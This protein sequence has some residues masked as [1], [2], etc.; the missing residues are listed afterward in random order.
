[1]RRKIVKIDE[2]KCNGCGDCVPSCAEGAIKITDGKARLI[3]ESLCDGFGACL[4][5]Y[6]LGA[7]T[8]EKRAAETARSLRTYHS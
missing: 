1:M 5:T 6:P 4:G 2:E 8:I 3:G 7:I